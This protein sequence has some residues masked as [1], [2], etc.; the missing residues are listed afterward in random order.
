MASDGDLVVVVL[1]AKENALL[2]RLIGLR[3]GGDTTRV[4]GSR[5]YSEGAINI[6]TSLVE[7]DSLPSILGGLTDSWTVLNSGYV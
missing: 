7:F 1:R 4:A 3:V 5:G 2:C 6:A